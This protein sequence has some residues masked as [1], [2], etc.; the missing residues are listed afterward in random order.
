M[1]LNLTV[2]AGFA[3][4]LLAAQALAQVPPPA[5]PPPPAAPQAI[6][7]IGE[8]LYMVTGGGGNTTVRVTS[9]G[10]IVVDSKNPGQPF[11]DALMSQIRT[12][13]QAPVKVLID[14]HHHAD[15][16]GNNGAFLAAGAKVVAHR[17]LP[18]ELDRFVPPPSNPD[19]KAPAKPTVTYDKTYELRLG[20]K[21][22]KLFH[23]GP[24]H[25]GADTIVYFPDLKVVAMGDELNA[26]IPNIDY[27]G[28]GA[29]GGFVNSLDQ[30][31]KLD[32]DRAVPGHGAEP[33]SKAQV[34]AF[35]DKLQAL[36]D[37]A[38]ASVKAGTRKDQFIASLEAED[39]WPFPATFWNASRTEGLW[40]EAGGK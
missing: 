2:A 34:K 17:N 32:W 5:P 21:A 30:A 25:T 16:T 19:L 15:H 4:A 31:L 40:A 39:L 35:R 8:G 36:L 28:G 37:R 7:P 9:D 33:W 20:G 23:F 12:V 24:A 27:A 26:A 13:S 6:K 22:V 3:V 10:L 11:Y 18:G 29:L 1:R 38:R 14:T